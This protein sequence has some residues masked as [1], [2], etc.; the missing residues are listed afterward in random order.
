MAI[1]V[2]GLVTDTSAA[3]ATAFPRVEL[4]PAARTI[5]QLPAKSHNDDLVKP[6]HPRP[7]HPPNPPKCRF[8]LL[9]R[10][11]PYKP[12]PTNLVGHDL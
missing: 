12:W 11:C 9:N 10:D 4:N 8:C 2:V 5:G 3:N 6:P 7:I 1:R